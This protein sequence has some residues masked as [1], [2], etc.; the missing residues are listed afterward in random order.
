M[1]YTNLNFFF[2]ETALYSPVWPQTL[3][4][5]ECRAQNS[6][7]CP[8]KSLTRPRTNYSPSQKAI[9][10]LKQMLSV[11]IVPV[12][13]QFLIIHYCLTLALV[14]LKLVTNTC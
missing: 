4:P 10:H 12:F 5:L 7:L 2:F 6:A 8:G 9:K 13:M 3:N 14:F 1:L 11:S